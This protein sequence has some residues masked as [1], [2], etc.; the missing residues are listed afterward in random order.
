MAVIVFP[1]L[2]TLVHLGPSTGGSA[3]AP[4]GSGSATTCTL[5]DRRALRLGG[6][7]DACTSP[8]WRSSLPLVLG[9]AAA[10]CFHRR[11]PLRGLA[12]TVFILPMMA[13]PVAVALVWTMMFH[14]QLGVL[15]YLLSLV[16]LPPSHLGLSRRHGHP[17]AGAGGGLALDAAGDADRARRPR[18][19][20]TEPYEAA[21]TRRRLALAVLPPHHPAAVWPF[22]V[23]A[24]DPHHRRAEGLR[25]DL[26]DHPGRPGHGQRDDQHLPLSAGVRFYNWATP[27][28][29]WWCSSPYH[30]PVACCCWTAAAE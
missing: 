21:Q 19:L 24:R 14:P 5:V 4:P 3:A 16:G 23:V 25:H 13:T 28:R 27:R 1:W 17:D 11:F 9:I 22:I 29:W 30:R 15:N 26:R 7:A 8:R 10:L 6:A 20:P 12:R 18:R 2:F